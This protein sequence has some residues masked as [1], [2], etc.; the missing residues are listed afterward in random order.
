[1]LVAGKCPGDDGVSVYSVVRGQVVVSAGAEL[2]DV[3]V[4]SVGGAL[5]KSEGIDGG[6]TAVTIS[7]V[8]SG[9]AIV[10]VTTADGA[11]TRKI[12]VK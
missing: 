12:T 1:M 8:D 9:V 5:L 7:D 10:R 11:A 3:R 4:Y 2:R 6:R